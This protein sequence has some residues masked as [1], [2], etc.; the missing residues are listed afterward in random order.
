MHADS[1]MRIAKCSIPLNVQ[2]EITYKCNNKCIFCYNAETLKS[3]EEL[4]TQ[5]AIAIIED[6]A[7]CGVLS[8]NFNGGEPLARE[9]YFDIVAA[10]DKTGLDMHMNT[11]ANLIDMFTAHL[12]AK[13][14]P[15]VCTTVLA[16][17]GRVHDKLSGRVGAF[18]AALT[19]IKNLQK[20]SVYVA[21]NLMLSKMNMTGLEETFDVIRECGI[22]SLLITRYVPC[23]RNDEGLHISDEEFLKSIDFLYRYNDEKKCFHR[24]AF[25]QPF[26]LCNV[27][28]RLRKKVAESNIACNIGLC[29]A[30]ISPNGDLAPCN[31][32]KEPLLGNLKEKSL[33]ELWSEF[34][35]AEFCT[36]KHLGEKCA[37]CSD[38][39][40][41]GGGCKGYNDAIKK[42][43]AG[44]YDI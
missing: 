19:G 21:V 30:S 12:I 4:E 42:G 17:D 33:L 3:K 10:A 24:I 14:F 39:I 20:S 6:L 37:L 15:S 40:N 1:I 28:D 35:G 2:F 41:C 29:T 11:N 22:Q 8:V 34:D 26:K 9:D 31:L 44:S 36:E 43:I 23:D 25:P 38:I 18:E 27:P 7:S 32:V 13:Y 16:G 5:E